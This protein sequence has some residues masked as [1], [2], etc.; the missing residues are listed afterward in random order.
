MNVVDTW[1]GYCRDTV[2]AILTLGVSQMLPTHRPDIY[3]LYYK[4]RVV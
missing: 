2:A 4:A 3:L 1:Y